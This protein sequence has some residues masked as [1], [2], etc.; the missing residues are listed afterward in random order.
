[1]SQRQTYAVALGSNR[2]HGRHGRPEGVIRA[3]VGALDVLGSIEAV[4]SIHKTAALGPAGRSFANAAAILA[5][6]LACAPR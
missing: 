5:T 4:S 2:P 3:A 1:M 6:R